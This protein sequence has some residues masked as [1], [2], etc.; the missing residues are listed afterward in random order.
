MTQ[1]EKAGTF[2]GHSALGKTELPSEQRL[3]AVSLLCPE[4]GTKVV[5]LCTEALQLSA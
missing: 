3:V 5:M 4:K 2:R 1:G